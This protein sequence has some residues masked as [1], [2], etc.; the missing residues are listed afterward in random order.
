M[1]DLTEYTSSCRFSIGERGHKVCRHCEFAHAFNG[2][3]AG[4]FR[5]H[6]DQLSSPHILESSGPF[7]MPCSLLR[8]WRVPR[9]V[10]VFPSFLFGIHPLQ[11]CIPIIIRLSI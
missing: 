2:F 10:A 8:G 1:S 9:S 7:H 4:L 5:A 11:L 3:H 6:T